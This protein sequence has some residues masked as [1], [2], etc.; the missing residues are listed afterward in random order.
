MD[1]SRHGNRHRDVRCHV[2]SKTMKSN[3]L[4][5]HQK[6]HKGLLSLNDNEVRE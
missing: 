2:C 3:N 4:K 5:R 6:T 1:T